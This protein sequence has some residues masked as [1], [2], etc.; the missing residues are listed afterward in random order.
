[1]NNPFNDNQNEYAITASAPGKI[2]LFGEHAVVYGQPAIAVPVNQVSARCQVTAG[3]SGQGVHVFAQDLNERFVLEDV[4]EDHP[5]AA[6]IRY[7]LSKIGLSTQPDITLTLTSTVPIAR[8]MGSG[9]A[10]STAVVNALTQFL[11]RPLPKQTVSDI[12]FDVEKIHHGT[13]SGID[14]TVVVFAKPVFF[15]KGN[16]VETLSVVTPL[17]F[18]IADTGI[19][20]QTHKVV[21]NVRSRWQADKLRY[22]RYFDEIGRLVL[23][24]RSAIEAGDLHTIGACMTANHQLLEKINVST[25][26]LDQLVKTALQAQALGAKLSGAGWGGNMIALTMPEYAMSIASALQSAGAKNTIISHVG[27]R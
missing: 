27:I 18:V 13:P 21:G 22:D 4:T 17:T 10:I 9:A 1:M 20:S 2:I 8:G 12:V 23:Q 25:P 7:T 24:A 16:P 26:M 14:N 3:P 5:I 11:A 15:Q 19:K 6:A